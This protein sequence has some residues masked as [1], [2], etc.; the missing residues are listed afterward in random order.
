MDPLSQIIQSVGKWR[1]A[2]GTVT[3]FKWC[4]NWLGVGGGCNQGR[5]R[6]VTWHRIQWGRTSRRWCH[7]SWA[8]R[9]GIAGGGPGSSEE[10][11]AH[12]N[13]CPVYL[14]LFLV[15]FLYF[16]LLYL[17]YLFAWSRTLDG[18]SLGQW[19]AYAFFLRQTTEYLGS[20][21]VSSC[22]FVCAWVWVL[23][24]NWVEA[25][26]LLLYLCSSRKAPRTLF[27]AHR[28]VCPK[29]LGSL[30]MLLAR[31]CPGLTVTVLVR[32]LPSTFAGP[33]WFTTITSWA[34][35]LWDGACKP[36]M[37]FRITC[38]RSFLYSQQLTHLSTEES[39]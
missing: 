13:N 9:E 5:N 11:V 15:F 8:V 34:C 23:T 38:A 10:C 1:S 3:A 20:A 31:A 26:P 21:D 35:R 39:Q 12:L 7:F 30:S 4:R 36:P 33:L 28:A 2:R 24:P 25:Q 22:H 29:S 6:Q 27:V 19:W 14:F 32:L 37:E 17:I 16:K 18:E